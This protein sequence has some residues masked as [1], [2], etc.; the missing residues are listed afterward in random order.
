MWMAPY[1][2]F[3]AL[4]DELLA[5]ARI[6]EPEVLSSSPASVDYFAVVEELEHI[7]IT[8]DEALSAYQSFQDPAPSIE[9]QLEEVVAVGTLPS[10]DP[11][12]IAAELCLSR[13][14]IQGELDRV[15]RDFAF[16]NHPDRVE[17]WLRS[18]AE[19]RMQIANQLIDEAKRRLAHA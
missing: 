14:G 3:A 2:D 11:D 10:V 17:D 15:R 9:P 19:Q 12:E 13:I 4:L 18:R 6:E 5:S 16:S 8:P 7:S 1:R